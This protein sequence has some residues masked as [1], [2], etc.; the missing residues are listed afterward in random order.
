MSAPK[1]VYVDMS[2]VDRNAGVFDVSSMTAAESAEA[3]RYRA[4]KASTSDT[5]VAEVQAT[6]HVE[7]SRPRRTRRRPDKLSPR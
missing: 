4:R 2:R 7:K 3:K 5:N 1:T 6:A